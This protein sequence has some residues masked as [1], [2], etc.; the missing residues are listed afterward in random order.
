MKHTKQKELIYNTV[1]RSRSHPSADDIYNV[2]KPEN[3]GLSLATVYR[4]LNAFADKGL[5]LRIPMPSGGARFD[6]T[7][8]MHYHM[9]C[10]KCGQLFDIS[11]DHLNTLAPD[12]M[13]QSGFEVTTYTLLIYGICGNCR[14]CI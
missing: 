8:D 3:P 7:L 5:I 11:L 14:A 6:G 12:V 9:V 10:E 13:A 4:N 1:I 2:L